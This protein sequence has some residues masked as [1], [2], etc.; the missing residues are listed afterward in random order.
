MIRFTNVPPAP[1]RVTADG[2]VWKATRSP[3]PG[4]KPTYLSTATR[5]LSDAEQPGP[6]PRTGSVGSIE[7]DGVE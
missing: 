4:A 2:G 6:G 1:Q 7:A 3:R 5:S